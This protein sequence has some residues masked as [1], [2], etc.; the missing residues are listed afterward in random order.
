MN[1]KNLLYIVGVGVL[2]YIIYKSLK[3]D[4]PI[5]APPVDDYKPLT[6]PPQKEPETI[7]LNLRER[8]SFIDPFVKDYD[9]SKKS[10]VAPPRVTIYQGEEYDI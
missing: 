6:S 2:G 9:S 3:K 7:V 5:D 4:K 10:T 1:R 8:K